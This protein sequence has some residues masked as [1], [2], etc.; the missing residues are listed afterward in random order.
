M[1]KD[2][3][4]WSRDCLDCQAAKIGRHTHSTIGNIPTS[5]R[6]D[7]IHVDIVGPLPLSRG[8][9]YVVTIIDRFTSWLEVIP[10]VT[11]EYKRKLLRKL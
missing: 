4:E 1:K 6:F 2:I 10:I 9:K 11:K 3:R 5:G 7:T 8:Y